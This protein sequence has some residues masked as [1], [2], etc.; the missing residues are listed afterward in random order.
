DRTLTEVRERIQYCYHQLQRRQLQ[1]FRHKDS[2]FRKEVLN[3]RHDQALNVYL[4]VITNLQARYVDLEK[5]NATLLF[6]HG[7]DELYHALANEAF[8]IE[9]LPGVDANKVAA[10]RQQL[11]DLWSTKVVRD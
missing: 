11:R 7:V 4:E 3:L 8:Q 1:S 6:R 5:V 10:F 9:Y 2:V